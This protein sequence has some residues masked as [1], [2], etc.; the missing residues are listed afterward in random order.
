MY[1]QCTIFNNV[2]FHLGNV[3]QYVRESGMI[4]SA[5]VK[6]LDQ[7]LNPEKLATDAGVQVRTNILHLG[8][9]ICA[10]LADKYWPKHKFQS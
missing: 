10:R 3:Y 6:H 4:D 1:M 7:I 5:M 9:A 8:K 2:I